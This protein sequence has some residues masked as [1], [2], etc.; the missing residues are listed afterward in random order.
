MSARGFGFPTVGLSLWDKLW[1]L[2]QQQAPGILK[3][4]VHINE[5]PLQNGPFRV[6]FGVTV[7]RG[8]TGRE[9]G[10]AKSI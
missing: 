9:L 6:C 4:G 5:F 7:L 2:I 3:I 8:T 1:T 10:E